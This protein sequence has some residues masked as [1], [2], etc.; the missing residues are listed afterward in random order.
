MVMC[1][2]IYVIAYCVLVAYNMTFVK[3][4]N[5]LTKTW[6]GPII[7]LQVLLCHSDILYSVLLKFHM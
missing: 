4:V 6:T 3:N 2:F 7:F 5:C 1:V